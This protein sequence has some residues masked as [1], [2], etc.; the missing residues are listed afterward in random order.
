MVHELIH[1]T[2]HTS[3]LDRSL[4]NNHYGSNAY[5]VAELIAE[6][7]SAFVGSDLDLPSELRVDNAP[8][9]SAWPTIYKV[10]SV[11]FSRRAAR[12]QRAADYLY[13]FATTPFRFPISQSTDTSSEPAAPSLSETCLA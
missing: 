12:A 3:R 5:A 8:Y 9:I 1:W 2:G 7:G 13:K 11:P 10:T 6:L 4:V